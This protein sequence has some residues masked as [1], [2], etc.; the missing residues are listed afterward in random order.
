MVVVEPTG[1]ETQVVVKAGGEELVCLFR[2]RVLANPG[3][4]IHV[5]P[6]QALVHLFDAETGKRL[7]A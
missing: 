2:E 7:V 3:E 6:D 1:S 4:T 5:A